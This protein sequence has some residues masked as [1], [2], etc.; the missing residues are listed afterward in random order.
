MTATTIV[1]TTW[2][3]SGRAGWNRLDIIR[4]TL[5]SWQ[6]NL[7][8]S[9][10]IFL[11]VADDGSSDKMFDALKVAVAEEWHKYGV[12]FTQQDRKGVGA[13]LNQGCAEA[14]KHG[15]IILHAVDDWKLLKPLNIDPWIQLLELDSKISAVRFFPHPDLTGIIKYVEPGIYAMELDRHH[16]AFATRPSLW[17][18]RMFEN[19]GWF[20]EGV[21]AYEC[22]QFYNERYCRL[23][24]PKIVLALPDEWMHVGGVELGDITP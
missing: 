12:A 15:R 17:H 10:D 9:D 4:E 8:S 22:E 7:I 1:M 16:F 18:S 14:I 13:S 6:K 21:S 24:G 2:L 20:D 5:I 3:P 23:L 11:H 19:Y